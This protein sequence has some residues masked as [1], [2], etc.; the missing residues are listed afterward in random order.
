MKKFMDKLLENWVKYGLIWLG[1]IVI[2][3]RFQAIGLV[4]SLWVG[5]IFVLYVMYIWKIFND[6][7]RSNLNKLIWALVGRGL[8][9]GNGAYF[10]IYWYFTSSGTV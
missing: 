5:G 2:F 8:A 4:L 6:E 1:G 10:S 9:Y 7:A 3:S